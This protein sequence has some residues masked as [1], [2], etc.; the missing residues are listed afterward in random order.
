VQP[1]KGKFGSFVGCAIEEKA[2]WQLNQN[3]VN[4]TWNST[5]CSSFGG[6]IQTPLQTAKNGDCAI[7]LQ[8]AGPEGTGLVTYTPLFSTNSAD[9]GETRGSSLTKSQIIGICLGALCAVLL[10]IGLLFFLRHRKKRNAE[11]EEFEKAEL[12][13]SA[14]ERQAKIATSPIPAY[15]G[16]EL[17]AIEK[18]E[19]PAD[20]PSE[21]G[22]KEKHEL[23]GTE[24]I[25]V[26]ADEAMKIYELSGSPID[27][28]R[29]FSFDNQVDTII[30]Y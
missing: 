24:K 9:R 20:I 7:L 16:I 28:D 29:K 19:L 5:D 11:T 12:P 21:L 4:G 2:S 17:E 18:T 27:R 13:D 26:D 23:D 22:G 6:T 10:A 3:F 15:S 30:K 1:N 25:E 8:Q 14:V